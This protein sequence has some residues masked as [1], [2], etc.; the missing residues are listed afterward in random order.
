MK[1]LTYYLWGASTLLTLGFASPVGSYAQ[2]ANIWDLVTPLRS[3]RNEVESRLGKPISSPCDSCIYV[4]TSGRII[5]SYS[6]G[7]CDG[8]IRGW[9]VPKD[10]VLGLAITLQEP[11]DAPSI[12]FSGPDIA[13][14]L[15]DT[16]HDLVVFQE[17][18]L[19]Y[20]VDDI[21][22]KIVGVRHLPGKE[23]SQYRCK[24]FP[25]YEPL[26]VLYVPEHTLHQTSFGEAQGVVDTVV[27]ELLNKPQIKAH[28][29]VY[30]GPNFSGPKYNKFISNLKNYV[31]KKRGVP[32]SRIVIV[33]AGK[34]KQ[35]SVDIFTLN[36][37]LRSPVAAP[38]YPSF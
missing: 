4:A 22:K 6:Q 26:G 13:H 15:T 27:I 24:G 2:V 9:N 32:L 17:T 28:F 1:Q 21:L 10:V 8:P 20:D 7:G 37:N 12:N 29:L 11:L 38:D 35:F 30:S 19:I 16:M 3:S 34:R 18:G 5:V 31:F 25:S 33:E 23:D 36:K 14:Y